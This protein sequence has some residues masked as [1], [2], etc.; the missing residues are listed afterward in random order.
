V[1]HGH[2]QHARQDNHV[3]LLRQVF[4]VHYFKLVQRDQCENYVKDYIFKSTYE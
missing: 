2:E 4:A 1:Q 3:D